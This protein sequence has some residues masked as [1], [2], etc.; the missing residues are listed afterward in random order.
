MKELPILFQPWKA[1]KILN[2]DWTLGNMQTRRVITASNSYFNGGPWSAL[3]KAAI[4]DWEGAYLDLGPS[5]AGNPGPYLHVR[6]QG[7]DGIQRIYP[8]YQPGD[9][10]WVKET[11][12]LAGTLFYRADG[13]PSKEDLDL[14]PNWKWRPSLF[15]PRVFSRI[16]LEVV[17][18]RVERVQ[19][20]TPADASAE[21]FVWFGKYGYPIRG[22]IP[23]L[24]EQKTPV[25]MFAE[26]WDRIN[27]KR[28]FG[29]DVNPWVWVIEFK[30]LSTDLEADKRTETDGGEHGSS[31]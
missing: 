26:T 4:P 27:A 17:R 9:R 20:I 24:L 19:E 16:T 5:P 28:G 14:Y 18:I 7:I 31:G 22:G 21:G 30:R 8:R 12:K 13:E 23:T 25:Q 15:M 11:W 6:F 2:W 10:L 3:A 29:W 1:K